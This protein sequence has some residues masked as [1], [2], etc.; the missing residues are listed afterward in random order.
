MI[1][2]EESNEKVED[3]WLRIWFG[4]EALAVSEEITKKSL[5]NLLERLESD[6]RVKVYRKEFST[7]KMVENPIPEIKEGWSI[8]CE[9]EFVAKKLDD[10]VQIV[11]EYGPSAAEILEPQKLSLNLGEC[12][13]IL[14][15]VSDMM[16][17]FARAGIGGMV[18]VRGKE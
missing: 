4:L 11:M 16:H 6:S 9:T 12:Q 7:A 10:V 1:S 3:G 8:V 2:K 13:N 17:R 18:V 5:E 15:G 14:N